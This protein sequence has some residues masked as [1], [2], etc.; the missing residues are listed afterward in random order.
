ML[1]GSI[2]TTEVG[3]PNEVRRHI[4]LDAPN[5]LEHL[6]VAIVD[7]FIQIKVPLPAKDVAAR[8]PARW[9]VA[10]TGTFMS[11]DRLAAADDVVAKGDMTI[12]RDRG[13]YR[14]GLLAE[15]GATICRGRMCLID[16][17]AIFDQIAVDP[18][19]RRKGVGRAMMAALTQQ[20][21]LDGAIGG[22][23]TATDA[24]RALYLQLGW[25]ERAPWTTAQIPA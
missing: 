20:A 18:A 11:I 5:G 15:D 14:A 4:L 6:G 9:H 19:H 3:Q 10:R 21:L 16:R 23:L 17:Y 7:P 24:G 12:A 2:L 22:L 13:A 8:L 25:R 1:E